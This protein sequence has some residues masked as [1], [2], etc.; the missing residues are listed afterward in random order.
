MPRRQDVDDN[1]LDFET[2]SQLSHSTLGFDTVWTKSER[3]QAGLISPW[4]SEKE[5]CVACH[6]IIVLWSE[7]PWGTAPRYR[8]VTSSI[9]IV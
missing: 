4:G 5:I 7:E 9:V 6:L 2:P 8:Q 1:Y 3:R